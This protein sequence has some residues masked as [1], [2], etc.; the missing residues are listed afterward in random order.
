MIRNVKKAARSM[1]SERSSD[2]TSDRTTTVRRNSLPA[3]LA[4]SLIT[5]GVGNMTEAD[6]AEDV[7]HGLFGSIRFPNNPSSAPAK[8]VRV[9]LD[10][11]QK[12]EERAANLLELLIDSWKIPA[13]C[14]I[15][16]I[17]HDDSKQE[18][19]DTHLRS[20]LTRGL[21]AAIHT[22]S[23]WLTTSGLDDDM[24]AVLAG[25][26]MTHG[27][28]EITDFRGSL[29]LGFPSWELLSERERLRSLPNGKIHSYTGAQAA[30]KLRR[31]ARAHHNPYEIDKRHPSLRTSS[32]ELDPRHTHFVI[33]SGDRLSAGALRADLERHISN[34][35]VS[36]DR[37]QTP[38]LM[39]VIGGGARIFKKVYDA[40]NP[41]DA[42]TQASVPVLV[43]ADSGGAA[44]D[45]AAY[46][47]DY[48]AAA[49]ALHDDE[50]LKARD[51]WLPEIKRLGEDT[52]RKTASQ[53]SFFGFYSQI[54]AGISLEFAVQRA[55]LND[56]PSPHQAAMCT[57]AWA[58]S[59]LLRRV[60]EMHYDEL[61]KQA[62]DE[63]EEKRVD[64]LRMALT[65]QDGRSGLANEKVVRT[66]LNFAIE[67]PQLDMDHLFL[68]K[69]NRC[70]LPHK[71]LTLL[72][73]I[74]AQHP[75]PRR[76][77]SF[78]RSWCVL[79]ASHRSG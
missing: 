76:S 72:P 37:I 36:G 61:L 10:S 43:I 73:E 25:L 3:L 39:L 55:L 21:A 7:E 26:A 75:R 5:Q 45:I 62:T 11:K 79:F 65:P 46:F 18:D 68:D 1:M 32:R 57:I 30:P 77:T 38:K 47:G 22:T 6:K 59:A 50:Y 53:L 58:E 8:F 54:Y 27:R 13:P 49:E 78:P 70:E 34:N 17:P 51:R 74:C 35:D 66:L 2:G 40:L 33:S 15:I 28:K 52:L 63:N 31:R 20:V 4:K 12:S 48:A 19:L 16:S 44:S 71:T 9:L 67:P 69:Y 23:A 64:L 29:C 24:G 60:L 41:D 42:D 56:C 14:A